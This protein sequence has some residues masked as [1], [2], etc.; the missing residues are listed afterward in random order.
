M[1]KKYALVLT[2]LC[3]GSMAYAA[4]ERKP[5]EAKKTTT[6][7]VSDTK[8][9][10]VVRKAP[11]AKPAASSNGTSVVVRVVHG[12]RVVGSLTESKGLEEE[13]LKERQDWENRI[14]RIEEKLKEKVALLQ[15]KAKTAV[16]EALEPLKED[17]EKLQRDGKNIAQEAE[18]ILKRRF[19]SGLSK[20]NGKVKKAIDEIA[21][22]KGYDIVLMQEAGVVFA[23][24]KVDITQEVIDAMNSEFNGAAKK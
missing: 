8:A 23:S 15:A 20:I 14:K 7:P 22:K 11:V 4:P 6:Q 10:P 21:A 18:V 2:V 3:I 16:S 5:A 24:E 1:I 9:A 12:Q 19:E 13:L 17:I